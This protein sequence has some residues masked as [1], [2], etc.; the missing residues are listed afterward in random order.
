MKRV[1]SMESR[2][3]NETRVELEFM[4]VMSIQTHDV[5]CVS[6]ELILPALHGA[7]KAEI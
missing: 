3:R 4:A 1:C 2:S 6:L 5:D 7:A